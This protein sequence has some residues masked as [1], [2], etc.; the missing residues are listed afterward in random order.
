MNATTRVRPV[1][2]MVMPF[3]TKAVEPPPDNGPSKIDFDALWNKALAPVIDELGYEA[4]RADQDS[5]A[6]IILE[7]LERL[8]FSDLVVADMTIPNGNVYYEI[9]VRHACKRTGCVL[10]SAD[11]T[12]P[13]FDVNQMRRILYPLPEGTITDATAEGIRAA[14][15]TGVRGLAQG[16]SP[17][18]QQIPG[19]PDPARIDPRRA[20]AIRQQLDALSAFQVRVREARLARKDERLAMAL[21]LRDDYPATG[22]IPQAVALEVASLLRDS[23]GWQQSIDYIDALPEP[24][25]SLDLLQEQRCLAQSKTGDH[26]LAIAALAELVERSGDSSERQGLIGGRHKRLASAAK[27]AGDLVA[28]RD[29]LDRAIEHYE[30]GMR[31]DLNDY[32]PSCNLPGLYK[33]RGDEGD[34]ERAAFAAQVAMA[35]CERA[36]ARKTQDEWTKQTLLTLAFDAGDVAGAKRLTKDVRREGGAGWK[37]DATVESLA[38]SVG[39]TRDAATRVALAA[40]LDELHSIA[41]PGT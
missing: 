37:L 7:M 11:W 26:R 4:V 31:L 30:A 19:F 33:E 38:R 8:Y 24:M 17:M 9:G 12:K 20:S 5:G 36:I 29:E 14:L 10:V 6:S 25:R 3:G 40:L 16:D 32:F 34:A 18:Y 28:Y 35:A 27:A 2:F 13:L 21:A 15:R 1:C 39:Q 41:A 22:T 23:G